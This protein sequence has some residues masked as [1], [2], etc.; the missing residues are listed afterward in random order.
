[1]K[2]MVNRKKKYGTG[3]GLGEKG[4]NLRSWEIRKRVKM[5]NVVGWGKWDIRGGI[6]RT[7]YCLALPA[8]LLVGDM[9]DE[10]RAVVH[11]RRLV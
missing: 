4:G 2:R 5:G 7:F 1:M 8:A 9:Q 10:D 11:T 6:I 3:K